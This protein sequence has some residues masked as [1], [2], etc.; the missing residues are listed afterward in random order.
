[1][2]TPVSIPEQDALLVPI[3]STEW[4]EDY[5]SQRSHSSLG[6]ITPNEFAMKMDL[7]KQAA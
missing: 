7:Q 6:N 5:N 1:M 3:P 2:N 4:K